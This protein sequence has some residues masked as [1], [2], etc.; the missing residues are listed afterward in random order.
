MF[1]PSIMDNHNMKHGWLTLAFMAASIVSFAQDTFTL[2]GSITDGKT[3]EDLI[4]VSIVEPA[5]GS[6]TVTNVYGFYSLTLPAGPHTLIFSYIGFNNDT[7]AID[8]TINQTHNLELGQST[9]SVDEVV[10]KAERANKHVTST[11][12]GV[13]KMDIKELNAVPVLFGE[14]DIMKAIQLMPGI[15][16]GGEGGGGFY[17][18]GGNLDQNLILLDEATVY[19]PSH[20]LGFFSVFNSDAI[21]DVTMYKSGVPAEFGGR[22]SSVMNVL[23]NEGNMKKYGVSGGIGLISARLTAEGPIVK[24]RGSFIVSGRRSYLDAFIPL[25]LPDTDVKLYFYDVNAKL[26][27]KIN[28]KNRIFLSGYYGRDVLGMEDFGF[29][30]GNGTGTFRWNHVFNEKLF[31]NT[32]FIFSNYDYEF[33][34]SGGGTNF[35][36]SSGIMDFN[37]KEDLTY[38]LNP[39]NT[40]KFGLN[41]TFHTYRPGSLK[42]EGNSTFN[43]VV[44]DN[45]YATET[46]VYAS[47]EQKIWRGLSANYGLRLSMFNRIGAGT[48]YVYDDNNVAIDSTVYG[49]GEEMVTYFG[50]EPR[51]SLT[52]AF[53]PSISVKASYHRMYQYNHVLSNSTSGTP[54][55]LWVPSSSIIKPQFSDQYS[56]GYFQNFLNDQL[57]VSLEGY[58]K[59]LYN[60]VDY[61][62]GADVL[63]N[64]KVESQLTFGSGRA[65][66]AEFLIRK[67]KG[68]FTGWISYTL[69]KSERKVDGVN[70]GNYYPATQDRTHDLAIVLNYKPHKRWT[71]SGNWV[72]NTGNAVTFPSGVYAVEGT[73]QP[74]YTERNGYRMPDYH[75]LDLGLTFHGK[76][77]KKFRSDWTLSIYNVYARENAYSITFQESDSNPGTTEAVQLSLFSIIP[78]ITWNFKF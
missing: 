30:W 31:S 44:L 68:K 40:L 42:A 46:A 28:D 75:R 5:T 20:L 45:S 58:Y 56:I 50:F 74:Y 62:N 55:D 3:G 4:G 53:T 27:Y 77:E 33:G 36:I 11:D 25:F 23:M 48:E 35:D 14:K 29:N 41:T 19:N 24:D 72:Y 39:K 71:V 51:L 43:S 57:E 17:V 32:S 37:L 60:V 63:L 52:Y 76:K 15:S 54:T 18:R 49:K 70:G 26:N 10:V 21:K 59:D 65:Y 7:L 64:E 13:V 38:Y 61:E 12:I 2:S 78:S 6:G 67:K 16:S 34:V 47:N 9:I 73:L 66:G 1:A 69:S 22:S 8:L